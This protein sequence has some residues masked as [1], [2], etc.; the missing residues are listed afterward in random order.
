MPIRVIQWGAG[1]NGSALVRAVHR[2][3]DLELVGCRV[4]SET[5]NGV[6][7]GI[8]AG[9]EEIGVTATND[10]RAIMEMDADVVLHCPRLVP[11]TSEN[12]ADV[13][14]LL[15][16]GKNVISVTGSYSYPA[17]HPELAERIESACR[18]GGTVFAHTGINPGFIAERLATT[19]TGLCVDVESVQ[20]EEAYDCSGGTEEILFGAMGFGVEPEE[21]TADG[22]FGALFDF[23]FVQLIHHAA[24]V[25]GVEL[26]SVDHHA[27]VEPAHRDIEVAGRVVPKGRVAVIVQS[28][29]GVPKDADQVRIR[30]ETTWMLA[31]DIPGYLPKRGWVIRVEGMPSLE[32]ELR[33]FPA[34]DARYEPEAMVGAAIPMIG[35][36]MSAP[37]G[38]LLPT[39]F[40]PFRK[41]FEVPAEADD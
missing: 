29:E 13:V 39:I 1:A 9:I 34:D 31:D 19:L 28:W 22:P 14:D 36:V 18:A 21:W 15:T 12:D 7:A 27:R 40:A 24:H 20:I 25:L 6:D 8:L 32:L 37:P 26:A 41:R 3:A 35:E 4:Y 10:R 5:K 38:I 11:D 30:K 33:Y 16:S 2:H 23:L 17:A